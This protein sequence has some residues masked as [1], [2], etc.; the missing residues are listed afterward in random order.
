MSVIACLQCVQVIRLLSV[1][2]FHAFALPL[3]LI[4][5]I[6][7]GAT[8]IIMSRFEKKQFLKLLSQYQVTETAVVPPLLLAFLSYSLEEKLPL[9]S[10]ELAWCGGAPLDT[11]LQNRACQLFAPNARIVQV[12]GMTECGWISTFRYPENDNSGSVGRVLPGYEVK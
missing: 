2:F 4:S 11:N 10:L 12:W 6:R 7:D 1:P 5:A 3:A 9:S 8:T